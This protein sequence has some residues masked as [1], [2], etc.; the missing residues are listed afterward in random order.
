VLKLPQSII[1]AMIAVNI[2]A[3]TLLLQLDMFFFNSPI[4]KF[5]AWILTIGA[6]TLTYKKRKKFFI[7]F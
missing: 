7:L 5:I 3:F 4:E 6:W 1:Y 2:T